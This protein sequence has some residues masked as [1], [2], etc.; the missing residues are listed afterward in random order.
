MPS[1]SEE[2]CWRIG[3]LEGLKRPGLDEGVLAAVL[4]VVTAGSIVGVQQGKSRHVGATTSKEAFRGIS[5]QQTLQW[6]RQCPGVFEEVVV[7]GGCGGFGGD[8]K[9]LVLVLKLVLVLC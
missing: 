4:A 7:G 8:A 6:W 2:I 9:V 5:K 3:L 1:G